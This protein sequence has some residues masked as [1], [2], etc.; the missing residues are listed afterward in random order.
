MLYYHR[1]RILLGA[2]RG[3]W[4]GVDIFL[5]YNMSV[6]CLCWELTA[7]GTG[8]EWMGWDFITTIVLFRL[9]IHFY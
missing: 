8:M 3:G 4:R 5:V 6:Y 9:Y 1:Q 7:V 2:V